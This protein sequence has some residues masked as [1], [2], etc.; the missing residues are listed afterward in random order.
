MI[1]PLLD[2]PT[3]DDKVRRAYCAKFRV[4]Y[5]NGFTDFDARWMLVSKDE[6]QGSGRSHMMVYEP[7]SGTRQVSFQSAQHDGL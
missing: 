1:G 3:E 4:S 5:S 7:F 2:V 6:M